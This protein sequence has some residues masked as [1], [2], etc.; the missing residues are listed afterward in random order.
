MSIEPIAHL[1]RT[2]RI[3]YSRHP[4]ARLCRIW[5][6]VAEDQL[7]DNFAVAARR[8]GALALAAEPPGASDAVA[9]ACAI[10]CMP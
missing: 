10:A 4:V 9:K 3:A 6:N 8:D 7:F 2:A 5:R 1:S